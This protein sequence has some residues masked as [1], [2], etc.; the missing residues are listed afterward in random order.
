D[1]RAV[2]AGDRV[3]QRGDRGSAAQGGG[4]AGLPAGRP[5]ARAIRG[6]AG[7]GRPAQGRRRSIARAEDAL[8]SDA[9]RS[10]DGAAGGSAMAVAQVDS[11]RPVDIR[12]GEIELR[13][14]E[15]AAEVEA[16]QAL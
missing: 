7:G 16:A 8:P 11:G 14:A 4:E 12:V 13:L 9:R 1:R 3:P 6:A 15:T 10:T 5:P 2:G